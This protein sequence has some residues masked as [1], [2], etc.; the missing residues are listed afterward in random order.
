[1]VRV[2]DGLRLALRM[3]G[4]LLL[5]ASFLTLSVLRLRVKL[6]VLC[7]LPSTHHHA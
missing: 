3:P 5:T 4:V 6:G 7:R 1:M 2:Y